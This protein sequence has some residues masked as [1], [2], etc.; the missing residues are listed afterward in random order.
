[1]LNFGW[2]QNHFKENWSSRYFELLQ[3]AATLEKKLRE[4]FPFV[5]KL[6]DENETLL[7]LNEKLVEEN[8]NLKNELAQL[9]KT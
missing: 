1:M 6:G 8:K 4:V 9:K 7:D 3:E 5:K 2:E